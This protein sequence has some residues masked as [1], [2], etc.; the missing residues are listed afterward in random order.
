MPGLNPCIRSVALSA[1]DRGWRI[2]GF[3]SG[4]KGV[5]AIDPHDPASVAVGTHALDREAVRGIDRLGGTILHTSR[6][7]PRTATDGDRTQRVLDVLREL[8]IDALITLGGD[9]TLRLSTHLF[10]RG[11]PVVSIPKTID[12]DAR[13]CWRA[14]NRSTS[15]I[16]TMSM[17][18][19][20]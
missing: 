12:N 6:L 8:G 7:D 14:P 4:W 19:E 2:P 18:I 20:R 1:L 9:G 13:R 10:E 16:S 3:R 5:L 17:P 15:P 11:F